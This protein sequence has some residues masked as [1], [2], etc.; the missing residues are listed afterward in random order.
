MCDPDRVIGDVD[1]ACVLNFVDGV[2]TDVSH[3]STLGD[4]HDVVP[5]EETYK[6]CEQQKNLQEHTNQLQFSFEEL[7]FSTI[8]MVSH[9][10][11]Y[12][13]V[14]R[15]LNCAVLQLWQKIV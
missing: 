12:V 7:I 8:I 14:Q 11:V 6:P 2:A 3:L 13:N 1:H 4:Q 5:L 15:L 10:S 9:T